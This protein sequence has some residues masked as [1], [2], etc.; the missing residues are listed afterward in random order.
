MLPWLWFISYEHLPVWGWGET[1]ETELCLLKEWV[2]HLEN[3]GS[4]LTTQWDGESPEVS[5]H[6]HPSPVPPQV[7]VFDFFS[8][9]WFILVADA[10]PECGTEGGKDGRVTESSSPFSK[11]HSKWQRNS[12]KKCYFQFKISLS[13]FPLRGGRSEMQIGSALLFLSLREHLCGTLSWQ[14]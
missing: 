10:Q 13:P 6:S 14:R 8:L 9:F 2:C 11:I 7:V 1:G 5:C 4:P 3:L 12:Q